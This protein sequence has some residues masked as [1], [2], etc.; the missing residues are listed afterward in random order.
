[1]IIKKERRANKINNNKLEKQREIIYVT[2]ELSN[3]ITDWNNYKLS[4]KLIA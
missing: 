1:M 4:F 3:R 2:R